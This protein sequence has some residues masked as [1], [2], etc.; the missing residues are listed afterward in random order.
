LLISPAK[1]VISITI[2][3]L[4][5][6]KIQLAGADDLRVDLKLLEEEH[7]VVEGLVY[8]LVGHFL[9]EVKLNKFGV[10]L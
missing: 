9:R 1:H 10:T 6:N 5:E 3:N 8:G 2:D 4:Q 7:D